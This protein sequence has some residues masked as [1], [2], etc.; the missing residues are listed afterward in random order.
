MAK[1]SG[2]SQ[3]LSE[4]I[5]KLENLGNSTAQ[6]FKNLLDQDYSEIKKS[7]DAL[8]PYLNT[9]HS[10]LEE[11][12]LKKKNE[13]EEKVKENPWL[14]LGVV[15]LVAFVIGLFLGSSRRNKD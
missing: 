2:D 7:L 6:D 5:K 14:A 8:K 1:G 13:A 3:S 15:G 4:A 12:I 11:E 9:L 10:N